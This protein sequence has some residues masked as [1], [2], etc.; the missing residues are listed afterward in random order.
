VLDRFCVS[1]RED[2]G[3]G[4]EEGEVDEVCR[5]LDNWPSGERLVPPRL[6]MR[7]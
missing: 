3:S 1:G 7:W 4:E 5:L 2:W 6:Q